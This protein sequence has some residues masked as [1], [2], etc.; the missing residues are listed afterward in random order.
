MPL[1]QNALFLQENVLRLWDI[2]SLGRGAAF[3]TVW[4]ACLQV[5][6]AITTSPL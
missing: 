3:P 2:V 1:V 6:G 4:D 5:R